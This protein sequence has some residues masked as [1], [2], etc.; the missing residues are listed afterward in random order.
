[1]LDLLYWQ[2]VIGRTPIYVEFYPRHAWKIC[3]LPSCKSL[4]LLHMTWVIMKWRRGRNIVKNY[5]IWFSARWQRDSLCSSY[6]IQKCNKGHKKT[7]YQSFWYDLLGS[8]P[9]H[10]QAIVLWGVSDT[11]WETLDVVNRIWCNSTHQNGGTSCINV[12]V[13]VLGLKYI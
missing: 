1:M 8:H 5:M 13:L 10:R 2:S 9:Q 4:Q 11:L 7:A 3:S 12:N 6:N